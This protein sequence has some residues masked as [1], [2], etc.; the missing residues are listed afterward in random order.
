MFQFPRVVP[1]LIFCMVVSPGGA[2]AQNSSPRTAAVKEA[3]KKAIEKCID[4]G[5]IAGAVTLVAQGDQFFTR[6]AFGKADLAANHPMDSD[7]IFW[8][9][10]M[11]KPVTGVAVMILAEQGKLSVDDPVSKYIPEFADLKTADGKPARI[12]IKHL[13]THTSG[14][15]EMSNADAR[16]VTTLAQAIPYYL[17]K[18]VAFEPGTK[19]VYCQSSINTAAR[20]VE[21]VSG[22]SFPDFLNS[23][24]FEPLGMRDTTFYLSAEQ[25]ARLAKSYK[26]GSGGSLEEA[27]IGFLLGK[28]PTSRDRYP[29]G[30]GGLFSTAG[31][32]GRFCRMLLAGGTLGGKRILKPETVEQM[33]TVQFPDIKTGFTPGNGWGLGCCVVREPQGVTAMLAPGSFGHGG[34]YG[35]QAWVDPRNHRVY[36]LMIQRADFPNSDASPVRQ[37]FQEA[38]A[39]V[40]TKD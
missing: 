20:V 12:T 9:A 21:I 1:L 13:L 40:L 15:G 18:P 23:R 24:I 33:T 32:Y 10:S 7:S 31:D 19:W 27:P 6:Q 35:T 28:S 30:N 5:E 11:S 39:S 16:K 4:D 14:L 36:V 22:Q 3:V 17:A 34:A 38:A 26:K 29:A 37:A 25:A 8:I 2:S